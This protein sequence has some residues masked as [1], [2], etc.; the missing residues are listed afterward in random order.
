MSAKSNTPNLTSSTSFAE[1]QS[2]NRGRSTSRHGKLSKASDEEMKPPPQD[3]AQ[4]HKLEKPAIATKLSSRQKV[5]PS[6]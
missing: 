3:H 6:T 4:N 2:N 1:T 5:S